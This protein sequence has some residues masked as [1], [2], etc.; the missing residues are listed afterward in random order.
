MS[1][2]RQS[3]AINHQG[4]VV[5]ATHL[6][7]DMPAGK[8]SRAEVSD[9]TRTAL[10]DVLRTS[11]SPPDGLPEHM[12]ELVNRLDAVS[13]PEHARDSQRNT[14]RAHGSPKGTTR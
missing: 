2:R 3:S 6:V 5:K 8:K 13:T 11:F 12:I 10:R 1:E 4:D 7:A 9:V 14:A